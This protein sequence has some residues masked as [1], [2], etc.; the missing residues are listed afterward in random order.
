MRSRPRGTPGPLAVTAVLALL[1]TVALSATVPTAGPAGAA[2]GTC[3]VTG[4][5]GP[6]PVVLIHGFAQTSKTLDKDWATLKPALTTAGA[7]PVVFDYAGQSLDFPDPTTN[8]ATRFKKTLSCLADASKTAGGPGQVGVVAH[9]MGGLVTRA[10]LQAGAPAA[11]IGFVVTISTPHEGATFDAA[12]WPFIGAAALTACP[13]APVT[14]PGPAATP[15]ICEQARNA[16]SPAARGM[17]GGS[18]QLQALHHIPAEVPM[19]LVGGDL[20]LCGVLFEW[21]G[22]CAHGSDPLVHPASSL[23]HGATLGP[24]QKTTKVDCRSTVAN[25]VIGLR[26]D[27]ADIGC[28]HGAIRHHAGTV[29]AVRRAVDNWKAQVSTAGRGAEPP[30][31]S[32][33]APAPAAGFPH[34]VT[35]DLQGYGQ[36]ADVIGK[37]FSRRSRP[38]TAA[39]AVG[40]QLRRGDEVVVTCQEYGGPLEGVGDMDLVADLELWDKLDD[41]TYVTDWLLDTTKPPGPDPHNDHPGR[42]P[43]IPI[44]PGT[45]PG[46]LPTLAYET[47]GQNQQGFGEVRPAVVYFGGS[48]SGLVTNISWDSWGGPEARGR[49]EALYVDGSTDVAHAPREPAVIVVADLGPCGGQARYRSLGWYFPGRGQTQDSGGMQDVCPG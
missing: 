36:V 38:D 16:T 26:N 4:A 19:Q 1:A 8:A 15:F 10:A 42:D 11:Q 41:G 37:A 48:P 33:T 18:P 22:P 14:T 27:L 46:R 32:T 12:S 25:F 34:R 35:R 17:A 30:R 23:R 9:S 44:C 43:A 39:P 31:A 29:D 13:T 49:G 3:D 45:S 5:P 21:D 6:Y 28:T 24:Q 7:N 47:P 2:T 20:E 40:T